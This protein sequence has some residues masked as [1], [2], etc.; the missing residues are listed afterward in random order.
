MDWR[1]VLTLDMRHAL[2]MG[3]LRE[4]GGDKEMT[5]IGHRICEPLEQ[6]LC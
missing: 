6:V 3:D 2:L 5:V 4:F 1:K